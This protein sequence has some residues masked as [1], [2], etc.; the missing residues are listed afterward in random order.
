VTK[1]NGLIVQARDGY[2]VACWLLLLCGKVPLTLQAQ[3]KKDPLSPL[4]V[5][6]YVSTA[7]LRHTHMLTDVQEV[8]SLDSELPPARVGCQFTGDPP[9]PSAGSGIVELR[10]C[11]VFHLDRLHDW[12]PFLC[13]LTFPDTQQE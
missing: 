6:P 11:S 7:T 9:G 3:V 10:L 2:Y 1:T 8:S 13:L 4:A 12:V 5:E